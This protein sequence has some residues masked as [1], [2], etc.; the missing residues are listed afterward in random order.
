ME[1]KVTQV[2]TLPLGAVA[3]IG[4]AFLFYVGY[5]LLFKNGR[6]ITSPVS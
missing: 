3:I 6:V 2:F 5:I 1:T 4:G